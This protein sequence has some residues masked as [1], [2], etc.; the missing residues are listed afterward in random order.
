MKLNRITGPMTA[1]LVVAAAASTTRGALVHDVT[2]WA[3]HNGTSTVSDGGTNSPTFTP[4]DDNMT[5]LGTFPQVHLANDGDYV[6]ATTTLT[7][8]TRTGGAGTNGL[9]T[10]LR[11][12]LVGGPAGPVVA[13]DLPHRGIW[14]EYGNNNNGR[15]VRE[16][17]PTSIDP[18]INPLTGDIGTLNP[19]PEG[20]SIQGTDIGPV[21]FELTLTRSGGNLVIAASISGTDSV[22]GNAF[23]S[24]INPAIVYAPAATGFNFDFNRVGFSFRGNVNAPNGTLH[25]VVVTTN[26]PEPVCCWLAA[27][28]LGMCGASRTLG[29]RRSA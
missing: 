26:V 20:D 10:Q 4:A 5:V 24:E 9:N 6:K 14:I 19:D 22:S 7:L 25:D 29:R 21:D 28:V 23:F 2:G 16:V 18:F 17:D 27:M 8:D 15:F 11:F 3:V 13:E 12:G 1:A